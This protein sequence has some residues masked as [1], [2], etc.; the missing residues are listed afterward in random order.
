VAQ[1]AS[2]R[3]QASSWYDSQLGLTLE[4]DTWAPSLMSMSLSDQGRDKLHLHEALH[5][6]ALGELHVCDTSGNEVVDLREHGTLPLGDVDPGGKLRKPHQDIPSPE[7]SKLSFPMMWIEHSGGKLRKPCP[8]VI[9][10]PV[11]SPGIMPRHS[12]AM[13]YATH[14]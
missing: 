5:A 9:T 4:I 1:L 6:F 12:V 14:R 3:K 7:G 2:C 11:R 8:R 13:R 10:R